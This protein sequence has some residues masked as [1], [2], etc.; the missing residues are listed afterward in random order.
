MEIYRCKQIPK[1][2]IQNTT[3]KNKIQIR[4]I[5]LSDVN[6]PN[7]ITRQAIKDAKRIHNLK[8]FKNLKELYSDLGI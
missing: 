5:L 2:K 7:E 1:N 3:N 6:V 4:K 8:R